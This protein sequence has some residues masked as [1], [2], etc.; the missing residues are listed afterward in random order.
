MSARQ[1]IEADL[2]WTG[3]AFE[4]GVQVALDVEGRIEAVGALEREP[5]V[6]LLGQALLPGLVDVHSHAFQRGL[7]GR[8][9]GAAADF[10]SWRDAMYAFVD[11]LDEAGFR[12]TCAR[13]F[14]E[15]LD[16]GITTVGEFHYLHHSREEEDW[17][18]D[19]LLVE[20]AA[21]V[22][23]RLA[24]LPTYYRTGGVGEPLRGAQWR[25]CTP[26]P[27]TYW[28]RFEAVQ[29]ELDPGRQSIGVAVHSVRAAEPDEIAALQAEAVRRG[30]PFHLH[31]EE[32]RGEI[33]ACVAAYGAPPMA[34][35]LERITDAGNVT[36]IHC[37]HTRPSDFERFLAVGGTAC[38]CPTTE[39]DLGDGIPRLAGVPLAP[40]R[41]CLGTDANTR[42]SM[43]EEMRWLEYGQRLAGE[44][45]DVLADESGSAAPTLLRLATVVGARSLGLQVGAIAPG[46]WGDFAA[47]DLDHPTLAD[48]SPEGILDAWIF[49]CG[50]EVVARSCVAGRWR[51]PR[52]G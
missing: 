39:A 37:T 14:A 46:S 10:W 18:F 25:F 50:N 29:R 32:Q 41:I 42:I 3:Q 36:A 35:F 13:A 52:T 23:I 31:M 27:E 8:P 12:R 17:A 24:L 22:G 20:T 1:V 26:D 33:E 51:E 28:E 4:S 38:V 15:M 21:E 44:R 7:R 30:L 5:T 2:V 34:V 11:A 48:C 47:L 45:R 19:R 16:A 49:G 6:R 43:V 9:R 40:R